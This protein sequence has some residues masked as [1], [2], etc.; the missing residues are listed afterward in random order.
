M[1]QAGTF[2]SGLA[3]TTK[4]RTAAKTTMTSVRSMPQSFRPGPAGT[5]AT[6]RN[7]A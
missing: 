5:S 6:G 2:L 4:I 7:A 3:V 1:C